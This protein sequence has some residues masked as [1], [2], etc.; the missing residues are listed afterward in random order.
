MYFPA[1]IQI[2]DVT[3]YTTTVWDD[4]ICYIFNVC[5][6]KVA[7]YF[8]GVDKK[9]GQMPLTQEWWLGVIY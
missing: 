9:Q 2:H 6:L 1:H 7:E 4:E 8:L 3:V 5:L